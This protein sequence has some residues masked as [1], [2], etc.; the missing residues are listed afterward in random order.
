MPC[1]LLL[2]SLLFPT[3]ASQQVCWEGASYIIKR[4]QATGNKLRS[5]LALPIPRACCVGLGC[6]SS[7]TTY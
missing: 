7:D 5:C 3:I 6:I 2:P 1:D 4:M